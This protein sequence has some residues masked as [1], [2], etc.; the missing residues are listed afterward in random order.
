[1]TF[2]N[3]SFFG[4]ETGISRCFSISSIGHIVCPKVG[5]KETGMSHCSS[6]QQLDILLFAPKLVSKRQVVSV[7]FSITKNALKEGTHFVETSD[8]AF[9]FKLI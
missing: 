5:V 6:I 4:K 1:M 7:L 9:S 8:E 2:K 3:H